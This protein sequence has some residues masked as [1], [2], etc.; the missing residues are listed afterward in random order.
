MEL[1]LLLERS[2]DYGSDFDKPCR[3]AAQRLEQMEKV[4]EAEIRQMIPSTEYAKIQAVQ[5]KYEGWPA[6]I[7]GALGMLENRREWL[8]SEA[9]AACRRVRISTDITVLHGAL[10]KYAD[11]RVDCPGYSQVRKQ[12]DKELAAAIADLRE[13]TVDESATIGEVEAVIMRWNGVPGTEDAGTALGER[14][15]R[16]SAPAE[17]ELQRACGEPR[18]SDVDAV[19]QK[20]IREGGPSLLGS[21]PMLNLKRHRTKLCDGMRAQLRSGLSLEDALDISSLLDASVEY[22]QDL[23]SDRKALQLHRL[24]LA[25]RATELMK[26][27][28]SSQDFVGIEKLL[29]RY[30]R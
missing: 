5:K 19:L 13:I 16:M 9:A 18:L 23:K 3:K 25:K 27:L 29:A 24:K 2:N 15:A 4:A 12:H 26:K 1:F 14:L 8:L 17:A 7:Q 11:Y 28:K 22:E 30:E 21:T 10:Q 6:R 20:Y